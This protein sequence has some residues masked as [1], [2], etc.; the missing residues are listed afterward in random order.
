MSTHELQLHKVFGRVFGENDAQMV[1]KGIK[2]TVKDE[3]KQH[4]ALLTTKQDTFIVKDDLRKEIADVKDDLR[5]EIAD[6]KVE[7]RKEIAG[8]K[9]EL[10]KEIAGVKDELQKQIF[11]I[12]ESFQKEL[13]N[14]K[15]DLMKFMLA[16]TVVIIGVVV[17]LIKIL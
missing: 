12:K 17:T 15:V 8:V 13:S 14:G 3:L 10:R 11:G 7:L 2:N 9:D 1:V 5:K 6:V 16:Q 4:L